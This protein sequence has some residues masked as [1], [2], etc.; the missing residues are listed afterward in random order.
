MNAA[1]GGYFRDFEAQLYANN[2][3]NRLQVVDIFQ[4]SQGGPDWVVAPPRTVG[5]TLRYH[6]H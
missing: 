2:L 4:P 6:F 5:L 1:I 3:A